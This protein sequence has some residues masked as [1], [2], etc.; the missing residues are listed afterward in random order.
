MSA[1]EQNANLSRSDFLRLAA[2]GAGGVGLSAMAGCRGE[3]TPAVSE[4]AQSPRR[5]Y[6]VAIT[7]GPDDP[8]R[9]MLA[10]ATASRLPKGDN[11]L[12]FA[13][14]GGQIAKKEVAGTVS[15]PLFPKQGTAAEMLEELRSGGVSF[16][17]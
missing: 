8:T 5:G 6:V 3:P 11:H 7:H 9:V 15:S 17:I 14:D 4:A 10:L 16:H 12:W 13:I 2:F 1:P